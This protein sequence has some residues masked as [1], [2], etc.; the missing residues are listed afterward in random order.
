MAPL[1]D[2]RALVT[3]RQKRIV[4][5]EFAGWL[6]SRRPGRPPD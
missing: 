2:V 4:A 1:D 5:T 3:M 6:S